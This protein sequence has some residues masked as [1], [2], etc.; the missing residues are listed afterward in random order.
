VADTLRPYLE[1]EAVGQRIGLASC[2]ECG[3][4]ILLGEDPKEFDAP[5]VHQRWHRVLE[6]SHA[7]LDRYRG[8]IRG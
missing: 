2:L 7:V 5:A 4:V 8:A 3:A 1:V 6:Q